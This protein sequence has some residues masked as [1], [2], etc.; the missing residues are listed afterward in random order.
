MNTELT[1]EQNFGIPLAPCPF[2]GFDVAP[3]PMVDTLYPVTREKTIW[4][5]HCA[6]GVGGCSASVLGFTP[7]EAICNWNRRTDIGAST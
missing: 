5:L 4:G 3:A 6:D 7:E 1:V 2:C